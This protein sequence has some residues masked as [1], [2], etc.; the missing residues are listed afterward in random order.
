MDER[1]TKIILSAFLAIFTG[2]GMVYGLSDKCEVMS[3]NNCWA[4]WGLAI[5]A[6]IGGVILTESFVVYRIRY[7]EEH[8]K[9]SSETKVETNAKQQL[10][11]RYVWLRSVVRLSLATLL[12]SLPVIVQGTF[13]AAVGGLIVGF[14]LVFFMRSIL[15]RLP[16]KY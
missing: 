12:L 10:S 3:Q 16:P 6:I 8:I 13:V 7:Y 1:Y 14:S 2:V 5:S 11:G 15:D 9:I 4:V